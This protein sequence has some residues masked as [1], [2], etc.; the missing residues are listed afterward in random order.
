[1][2]VLA[3]FYSLGLKDCLV[4]SGTVA[5]QQT[6]MG[7]VLMTGYSFDQ[8]NHHFLTSVMA[9]EISGTGYTTLGATVTGSTVTYDSASNE[10]RWTFSNPTWTSASFSASQMAVY[11]RSAG[12]TTTTWPLLM[13]VE[14]GATQTVAS[15][16][17]QY[18]VPATGAGAI[19]VS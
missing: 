12:G 19:T 1:M 3:N 16:T 10:I 2:A 17:F 8:D 9:N 5:L 13:Y 7:A 14:F 4:G 15:G 6:N 11:Y 18:V